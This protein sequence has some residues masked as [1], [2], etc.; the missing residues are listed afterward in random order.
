VT[1]VEKDRVLEPIAAGRPGG[2]VT[3]GQLAAGDGVVVECST[4]GDPSDLVEELVAVFKPA[5]GLHAQSVV[6]QLDEQAALRLVGHLA[7]DPPPADPVLI[8]L[9]GR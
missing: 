7:L 6:D 8:R 2:R 9:G 3:C 5:G 1:G 4:S